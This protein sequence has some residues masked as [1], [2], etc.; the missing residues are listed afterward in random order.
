MS[1]MTWPQYMAARQ[2]LAEEQTG[3]ASRMAAKIEQ[4]RVDATKAAIRAGQPK[5]GVHGSG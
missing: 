3:S 1:R 2:L 5:E 4:D